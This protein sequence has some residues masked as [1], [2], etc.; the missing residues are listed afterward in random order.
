MNGK[1]AISQICYYLSGA[2]WF[3]AAKETVGHTMTILQ[4]TEGRE[5]TRRLACGAVPLHT[6]TVGKKMRS[7]FPAGEAN[8]WIARGKL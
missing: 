3:P 2:N 6:T 7:S 8:P 1:F 4:S 5:T